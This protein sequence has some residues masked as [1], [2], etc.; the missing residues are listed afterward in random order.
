MRFLRTVAAWYALI[1][2]NI[3]AWLAYIFTMAIVPVVCVYIRADDTYKERVAYGFF[4]VKNL[5]KLKKHENKEIFET[6][7]GPKNG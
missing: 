5:Y 6:M 1:H 3:V 7:Q 2:L 4:Y